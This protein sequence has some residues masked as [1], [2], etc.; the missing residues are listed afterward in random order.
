M[1]REAMTHM[2]FGAGPHVCL[3]AKFALAQMKMALVSILHHYTFVLSPKTEV[4]SPAASIWNLASLQMCMEFLIGHA[5]TSVYNV[6]LVC[7]LAI[8]RPPSINYSVCLLRW[9]VFPPQVPLRIAHSAA[10]DVP[11]NG[12][13]LLILPRNTTVTPTL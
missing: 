8:V 13:V 2:P 10:A 12:V 7:T 5:W 3:G 1:K 9:M 4:K 11:L 6:N